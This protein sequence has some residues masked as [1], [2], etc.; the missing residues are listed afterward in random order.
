MEDQDERRV[1]APEEQG[2]ALIQE[3]TD[4]LLGEMKIFGVSE[5]AQ[6][7]DVSKQ[8]ADEIATKRLGTPW[9]H[10]KMGRMWSEAQVKEF[11]K[12]WVRKSGHHTELHP[13]RKT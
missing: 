5:L 2:E 13:W 1:L 9:R 6:R 7:W 10:L 11:E 12:T 3:R 4:K 8:R